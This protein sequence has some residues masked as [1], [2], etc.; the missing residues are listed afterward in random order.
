MKGFTLIELLIVIAVLAV[1]ST[2]VVL[3]L[4]PA[5][6]LKQSRDSTRLSD[7]TS[8]NRA[9]ALYLTDVATSTWNSSDNCTSGTAL[10]GGGVCTA[11]VGTAVNSTGWVPI[12]FSAISVGSPLPRLPLDPANGGTAC[13]GAVPG[14]FYVFESDAVFGSYKLMANLESQ[15]YAVKE[16]ADGGNVVDWYEVGRSLS[17]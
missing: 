3:V 12:N 4:N 6:I 9:I 11:N 10:P 1:L 8:V 13:E 17:L 7:L 2:G 5:E 16:S 14:C 15:K